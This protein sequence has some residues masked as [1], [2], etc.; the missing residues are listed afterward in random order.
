MV[1]P[2]A[3][4]K[5]NHHLP[6]ISRE[7]V[8]EDIHLYYICMYIYI[9]MYIYVYIYIYIYICISIYPTAPVKMT[10]TKTTDDLAR[11]GE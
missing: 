11:A 6:T 2:T 10:L 5:T 8:N 7:R 9:Y 1:T 3:P 4:V